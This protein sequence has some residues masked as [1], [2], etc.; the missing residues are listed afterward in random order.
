MQKISK[1]D[2][3]H[4][5]MVSPPVVS[6][7]RRWPWI[8]LG[9][10]VILVTG[11]AGGYSGYQDGI[12]QRLLRQSD[13]I[14]TKAAIQYNLGVA[15]LQEKRYDFARQRFEYVIQ[16]VP[17]FP[18]VADKLAEA[19]VAMSRINTPT[20]EP[21]ATVPLPTPTPDTRNEEQLYAQIN[22]YL[23]EKQWSKAIE[24]I[25]ALR[26][27]NLKYRAVEVDDMY[28][29]ALR[30]RGVQ[31]ILI[32]GSLEPGMYDLAL[33]ERFGPLDSD[34]DSYRTWARYYVTGA[35]FWKID[36]VQVINYFSEIY[37]YLPNLRD[38]SG[39]TAVERFRIANIE[40]ANQ[41]VGKG[42]Y[43]K[44]Q[45][46][47]EAALKVGHD[48]KVLPT[49]TEVADACTRSKIPP[50]PIPAPAT[51][52]P[53]GTIETPP[54]L[55]ETPTPTAP[56]PPVGDTPTPTPT[57]TNVPPTDTPVPPTNT[58]VPPTPTPTHTETP[59]A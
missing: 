24:T 58:P 47:L 7:P 19:I 45:S 4:P 2:Q 44:A 17:N 12:Q 9:I 16:L 54:L 39:V 38:G 29:V 56:V 51:P 5:T 42:D 21:T 52:T 27:L 14:M 22:Q 26:K 6:R 33:A 25:E 50:T 59:K 23:T 1:L 8:L 41:L 55:T 43:C 32:E 11:A 13:Q 53:T 10:I 3:T 37:P 15:D 49:A 28:Y 18:G 36:W 20:P 34:A 46:Y 48:Q 30:N 57:H 35:S 40:Y 31:K